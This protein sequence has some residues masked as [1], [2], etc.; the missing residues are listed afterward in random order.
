MDLL[1]VMYDW[2]GLD[3]ELRF[4]SVYF[5]EDT[6]SCAAELVYGDG[7]YG[8][9]CHLTTKDGYCSTTSEN[10]HRNMLY[11]NERKNELI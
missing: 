11:D 10:L 7:C 6:P 1:D 4:L 2:Y 5:C 3:L 8:T 9:H